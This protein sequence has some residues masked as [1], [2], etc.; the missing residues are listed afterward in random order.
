MSRFGYGSFDPGSNTSTLTAGDYSGFGCGYFSS[1]LRAVGEDP[2]PDVG[3]LS[4]SPTAATWR[5]IAT[6]VGIVG[7]EPTDQLL[8]Y[9]AGDQTGHLSGK[10][11][12]VGSQTYTSAEIVDE[13]YVSELGFTAFEWLAKEMLIDG[14]SYEVSVT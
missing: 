6:R 7:D 13:I 2:G 4:S 10:T 9:L 11:L 14:N 8:V 3:S 12:T 1:D 5:C